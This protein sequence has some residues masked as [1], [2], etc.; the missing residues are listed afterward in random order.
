MVSHTPSPNCVSPTR[1]PGRLAI[2]GTVLAAAAALTGCPQ[3][4]SEFDRGYDDGF[5]EDDRYFES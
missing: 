2:F 3:P 5:A 4:L 1:L